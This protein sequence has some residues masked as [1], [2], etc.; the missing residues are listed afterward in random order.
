MIKIFGSKK[1]SVPVAILVLGTF[2][3]CG[4]ALLSFNL[5][6]VDV[7][8]EFG[9]LNHVEKMNSKVS[10]YEFYKDQGISEQ[11]IRQSLSEEGFYF[12]ED[13]FEINETESSFSPK[14]SLNFSNWQK[15]SLKFSVKHYN[16]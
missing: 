12:I 6:T 14:L 8:G 7:M 1:A 5:F 3:V 16:R 11:E 4:L 10:K 9:D 13:G 15:E 2:V